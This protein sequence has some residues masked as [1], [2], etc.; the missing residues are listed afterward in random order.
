M[1]IYVYEIEYKKETFSPVL[2]DNCNIEEVEILSDDCTKAYYFFYKD[3]FTVCCGIFE[4]NS[5]RNL[6]LSLRK[7][8][9]NELSKINIF[10]EK[11]HFCF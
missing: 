8:T 6:F 2:S 11:N 3:V 5:C 7:L 9:L 4:L 10:L 1:K